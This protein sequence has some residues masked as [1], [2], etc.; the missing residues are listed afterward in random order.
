MRT[1]RWG[2]VGWVGALVATFSASGDRSLALTR[3]DIHCDELQNLH[4]C[5]GIAQCAGEMAQPLKCL[6]SLRT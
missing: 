5:S 4:L 2:N 1:L 3:S 6:L